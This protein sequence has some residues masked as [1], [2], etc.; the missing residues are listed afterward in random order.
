M[1]RRADRARRFGSSSELGAAVPDRVP[2]LIGDGHA[3]GGPRL[4]AA[5]AARSRARSGSPGSVP[6]PAIADSGD[7]RLPW[8]DRVA[9]VNFMPG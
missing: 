6:G 8:I 9:W 7:R 2:V 4:R 3:P 1:A 5:A